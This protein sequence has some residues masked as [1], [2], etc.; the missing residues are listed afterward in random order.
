MSA[1]CSHWIGVERRYCGASDGVRPFLQGPACP[2]HTPSA[3]AG[4]PEPQPGP[5]MPARAEP[6]AWT[7][8]PNPKD[9]RPLAA[10][11]HKTT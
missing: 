10:V 11:D 4:K 5:G 9:R 6:P 8:K 7:R 2:L 3:L 1:S